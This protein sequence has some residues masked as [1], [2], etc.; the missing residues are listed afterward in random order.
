MNK[1]I[2]IN[3]IDCSTIFTRYG[4]SVSYTK[5]LGDAG[6]TMLDGS[7][8][9]DV[10]AVRPV[11]SLT[12]MPCTEDALSAFVAE[13]YKHE[14]AQVYYYDLRTGEY[15]TIEAIYSEIS[16][17]HRLTGTDGNDYWFAGTITFEGR[18]PQ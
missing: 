13:L 2:K 17:T 8:T 3:D 1:E 16:A 4:Y 6:G 10:I 12:F 5:V 15:T 11:I 14:Y 9:E 18:E 7:V